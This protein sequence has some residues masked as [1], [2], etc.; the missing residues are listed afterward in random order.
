MNSKKFCATF[1]DHFVEKILK[2]MRKIT[3]Y[4]SG[5]FKCDLEI[6]E[7]PKNFELYRKLFFCQKHKKNLVESCCTFYPLQ[8]LPHVLM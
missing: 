3:F 1:K 8:K 2:L 6:G 4:P 7:L 5:V